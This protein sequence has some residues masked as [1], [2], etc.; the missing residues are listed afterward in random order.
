M[1]IVGKKGSGKTRLIQ[2][3]LGLGSAPVGQQKFQKK[4]LYEQDVGEVR[5][6]VNAQYTSQVCI[7]CYRASEPKSF[8][9]ACDQVKKFTSVNLP[10]ILVGTHADKRSGEDSEAERA[11]EAKQA[12]AVAYFEVAS[13]DP[14]ER[15]LIQFIFKGAIKVVTKFTL[16][17]PFPAFPPEPAGLRKERAEVTNPANKQTSD[18][19]KIEETLGSS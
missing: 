19:S 16:G 1:L 4:I 17:K 12:G 11:L 9:T 15:P 18:A 5:G 10:V 8:K 14:D 13:V 3:V 6:N 7:L 2:A